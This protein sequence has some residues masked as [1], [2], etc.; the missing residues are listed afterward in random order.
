MPIAES[1]IYA[2]EH[3]NEAVGDNGIYIAGEKRGLTFTFGYSSSHYEAEHFEIPYYYYKG[4]QASYMNG[5]NEGYLPVSKSIN[6]LVQV[7]IPEELKN[8]VNTTITVTYKFTLIT[9]ICII[10]SI[11]SLIIFILQLLFYR[12][13]PRDTFSSNVVEAL[14]EKNVEETQESES[15]TP[16]Q[17]MGNEQVYVPHC[18]RE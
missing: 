11:F 4:Y 9:K 15:N 10:V 8:N 17:A 7:Q 16:Q 3:T 14:D 2:R 6:G 5:S 18:S 1:N 13:K 12:R